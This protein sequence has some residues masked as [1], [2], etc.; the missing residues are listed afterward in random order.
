MV[1]IC[2]FTSKSS[3]PCTNPLGIIPD[4][5]GNTFTFM[6]HIILV[7]KKGLDIHPSFRFLLFL[8]SSLLGRQYQP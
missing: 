2:I 7:L 6:F 8:L 3:T 5:I 1:S 4:V